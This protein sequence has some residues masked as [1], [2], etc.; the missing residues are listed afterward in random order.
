MPVNIS[1]STCH[2]SIS[3][4]SSSLAYSLK[5][6]SKFGELGLSIS[7]QISLP[8]NEVLIELV[9]TLQKDKQAS[10]SFCEISLFAIVGQLN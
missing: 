7:L 8:F 3:C 1:L 6:G 10:V 4:L 2:Q 5:A 9:L